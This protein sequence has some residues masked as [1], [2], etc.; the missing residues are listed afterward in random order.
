MR[1]REKPNRHAKPSSPGAGTMLVLGVGIGWIVIGA[2]A[3]VASV[4]PMYLTALGAFLLL[5]AFLYRQADRGEAVVSVERRA[6][7]LECRVVRSQPEVKLS[8]SRVSTPKQPEKR[9]A[10][11]VQRE[12]TPPEKS[13]VKSDA[14][15]ILASRV[16][17]IQDSVDK[18][19]LNE[20]GPTTDQNSYKTA[21][22]VQLEALDQLARRLEMIALNAAIEAARAKEYGS[23]F[24]I[25][26]KE[27]RGISEKIKNAVALGKNELKSDRDLKLA[28]EQETHPFT[29]IVEELRQLH[30]E[31]QKEH[32]PE[33]RDVR[34]V[35]VEKAE[36]TPPP[37]L[38]VRRPEGNKVASSAPNK[39]AL[40]SPSPVKKRTVFVAASSK[41]ST[42]KGG[43][44]LRLGVSSRVSK[45]KVTPSYEKKPFAPVRSDRTLMSPLVGKARDQSA[46]QSLG[47]ILLDKG[48]PTEETSK[49]SLKLELD[50]SKLAGGRDEEDEHFERF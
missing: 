25:V 1:H 50:G 5:A 18:L 2:Y 31:I 10:I 35:R 16:R 30:D 39:I 32:S 40:A 11:A 17:A 41:N 37:K 7:E 14:R 45:P 15:E 29:A 19:I 26:A 43:L 9:T 38:V 42:A 12:S 4:T 47:V 27:M 6:Q 33:V 22:R 49:P 13:Q 46:P 8:L 34:D 48:G 20:P 3:T 21:I 44:R 23:G 28:S 24:S 36:F